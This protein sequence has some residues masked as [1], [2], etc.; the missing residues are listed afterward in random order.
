ME[1]ERKIE[2]LTRMN[3]DLQACLHGSHVEEAR[4]DLSRI[5]VEKI[6]VVDFDDPSKNQQNGE[7]S[8]SMDDSN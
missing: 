8:D 7:S 3:N 1:K 6:V 2:Q 5:K 4:V